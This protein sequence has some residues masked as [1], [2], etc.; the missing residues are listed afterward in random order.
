M[1][2]QFTN[3]ASIVLRHL[4]NTIPSMLVSLLKRNSIYTHTFI[5]QLLS[6]REFNAYI[7]KPLF[8]AALKLGGFGGLR[9]S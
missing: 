6:S 3:F 5:G 8:E 4:M 1:D 2:L 7:E 9:V